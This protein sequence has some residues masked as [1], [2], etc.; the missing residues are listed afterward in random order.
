MLLS[1]QLRESLFSVPV[2]YSTF[3]WYI[4]YYLF[5]TR[6]QPPVANDFSYPYPQVKR[7]VEDGS[8]SSGSNSGDEDNAAVKSKKIK[9]DKPTDHLT[10]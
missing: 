7:L 10:G 3:L 8:S 4:R 9:T 2:K 6:N 5:C 1:K